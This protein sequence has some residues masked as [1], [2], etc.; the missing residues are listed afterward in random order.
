MLFRS[1]EDIDFWVKTLHD[2][3]PLS[4]YGKPVWLHP[5]WSQ[6]ENPRVL[7]AITDAVKS[8]FKDAD[9]RAGWQLHKLFNADLLD[10]RSAPVV[11]LGG[12]KA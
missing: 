4:F 10:S 1:P 5:E 3:H 2:K 6:R 11:P 8:G 9:F 12:K 7:N